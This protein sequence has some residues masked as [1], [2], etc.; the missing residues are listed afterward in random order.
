MSGPPPSPLLAGGAA[1]R[2]GGD[3][4]LRGILL[5][6]ISTFFFSAMHA[7]IREVAAELHPFEIAFFRNVFALLVIVPWFVRYGLQPLRTT[8]FG[9]HILRTAFNI[10]AMLSFFY[11]LTIT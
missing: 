4:A 11:A 2:V 1:A 8:R 6:F 3:N 7:S 9:L 10:L 5:M